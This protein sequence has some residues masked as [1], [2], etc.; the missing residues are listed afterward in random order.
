MTFEAFIADGKVRKGEKDFQKAKAL[1]IMAEKGLLTADLLPLNEITA[2]SVLTMSYESLREILEAI[3]LRDGYKIYS[4]E[5]YTA[6]LKDLGE[7]KIAFLFDRLRIL[8]NGVNYYGKS[9]SIEIA[10]EAKKQSKELGALLKE[11]YIKAKL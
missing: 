5:A 7:E 6:Y 2:S 4:H 10:Q 9:V 3:C 11:K 8:R 1:L